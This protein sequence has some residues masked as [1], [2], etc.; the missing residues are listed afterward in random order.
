MGNARV[1]VGWTS[2]YAVV[3]RI[4]P[5]KSP[6]CQASAIHWRDFMCIGQMRLSFTVVERTMDP[7]LSCKCRPARGMGAHACPPARPQELDT[8]TRSATDRVESY[9]KAAGRERGMERW[10]V[11][12]IA[13]SRRRA[14]RC[15]AGGREREG[16]RRICGGG[17]GG[18]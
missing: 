5:L 8:G 13:G 2:A 14:G 6:S 16:W 18:I 12:W 4:N 10:W 11:G 15:R 3:S 7:P 9:K 1:H 17:H